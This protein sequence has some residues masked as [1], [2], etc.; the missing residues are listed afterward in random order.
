MVDGG[1]SP[2]DDAVD[3]EQSREA[4]AAFAVAADERRRLVIHYL[5]DR[6]TAPLDE[7]AT[8]VS[9]WTQARG[10]DAKMVTPDERERVRMAL[11]HVHL[12]R[13][14]DAGAVSYDR[15]AGVVTLDAPSDLLVSILER[16]LA[17]ERRWA[18]ER[19]RADGVGRD[20]RRDLDGRRG[21]PWGDDD[22]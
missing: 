7:L 2:P 9:G 11:H 17:D 12:P 6:K 18:R 14:V 13:L 22:A 8:V 19:A 10:S 15:D 3:P 1:S 16:S 5:R 4:D 20:G 21:D